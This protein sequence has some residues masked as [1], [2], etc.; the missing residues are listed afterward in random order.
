VDNSTDGTADFVRQSFPAVEVVERIGPATV[1]ELWGE[2]ILKSRHE[3]VA[4]TTASMAPEAGWARALLDAYTGNEWAGVGGVVLPGIGLDPLAAAVYWLR[5]HRYAGRPEA[6]VASDIPGD[7]GS[8]RRSCLAPYTARIKRE[9][10]WEYEINQD[11]TA[12]GARLFSTPESAVRYLG[13]ESF[14]E[15]A[16]Q[17]VVHG[18]RFGAKRIERLS[19]AR[20]WLLVALWPLTPVAFLARIVGGAS[21]AGGAT[22]L[23][24]ASAPLLWL[25][26]C[27][28]VGE[29][30]G[31]VMGLPH[32]SA[33][34]A[35]PERAAAERN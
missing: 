15:F 3:I 18:R 24:R 33:Q 14:V 13:G 11:L 10:F 35:R 4:L 19:K 6:G 29:L 22:S 34:S 28:S 17:R 8:Y 7:N 1:P 5:Y 27:W 16:R 9:G 25:L 21:R 12:G 32:T 2:G 20:T 26:L 31:Y 30:Q 23:L